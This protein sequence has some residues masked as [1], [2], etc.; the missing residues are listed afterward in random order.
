MKH[1]TI[2]CKYEDLELKIKDHEK[3]GHEVCGLT[4]CDTN[5]E[6]IIVFKFEPPYFDYD[7][8]IKKHKQPYK[9]TSPIIKNDKP[10]DITV[11]YASNN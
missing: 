7:D 8:M 3:Y 10:S 5:Q 1:V 9:C 11:W 4:W 6:F 2:K